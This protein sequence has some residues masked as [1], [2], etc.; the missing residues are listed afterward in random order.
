MKNK[1]AAL[2]DSYQS[3]LDEFLTQT[4]LNDIPVSLNMDTT[5]SGCRKASIWQKLKIKGWT[6][7]YVSVHNLLAYLKGKKQGSEATRRSYCYNLSKFCEFCGLMPDDLIKLPIQQIQAFVDSFVLKLRDENKS[8]KYIKHY[9]DALKAF[10]RANRFQVDLDSPK[11]PA[12]YHHRPEYVPTPA[13]ALKM[14]EC[15]PSLRDKVIILLLAFSGLRISTLLALRIKD[16][17]VEIEKNLENLCIPVYPQMKS[18]NPNACKGNIPYYTFTIKKATEY[19]KLYLQ[20]RLQEGGA[21][22][23]ESPVFVTKCR[24]FDPHTREKRPLTLHAVNEMIKVAAKRAGVKNWEKVSSLSLRKTFQLFLRS[25]PYYARLDEREQEFLFGHILKGSQEN[26]FDATKVEM[27]RQKFARMLPDP[28]NERKKPKQQIVSLD[29][30]QDYLNDGWVA[31]FPL[32]DGRVI[33]EK[34]EFFS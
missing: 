18:V 26:Y 3:C 12:R 34:E 16:I 17:M 8:L 2:K 22:D 5:T 30:L 20:E 24:R 19:L 9:I 33:V 4:V 29:Q 15:A 32:P 27:M 23:P 31:K 10:F 21:L 13:E 28:F 11:I 25:Q 7:E 14:A 1:R 6:S